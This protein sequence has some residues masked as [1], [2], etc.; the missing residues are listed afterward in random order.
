M[1]EVKDFWEK[2]KTSLHRDDNAEFYRRKA[3]EHVGL[4]P[5]DEWPLGAADLGCGAGE[6]LLHV[7]DHVKVDVGLDYSQSMLDQ[8]AS[9]LQGR[10][11]E[12]RNDDIFAYL[13]SSRH[14]IWTTTGA[15]NQYLDHSEM[16]VFLDTFA[17][18]ETARSLYCFDCVDPLRFRLLHHAISYRP[19]L[20][21]KDV[22]MGAKLAR[23][24]RRVKIAAEFVSGIYLRD[25]QRLKGLHMGYGYRPSF[26]LEA[27][28]ARGLE[29][30][31]VSSRHY[32]YRYHAIIRKRARANG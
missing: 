31:I 23:L 5:K 18:N 25:C 22:S 8:A 19:S 14:A 26:W 4:I 28:A 2:Q 3:E 10:N 13:P 6:L 7:S 11:I 29:I 20:N 21:V 1:D 12:L 32:E 17:G 27:A 9:I 16:G 15:I 30:E 24:A